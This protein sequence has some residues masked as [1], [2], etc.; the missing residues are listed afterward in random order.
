VHESIEV[1]AQSQKTN[2]VEYSEGILRPVERNILAP[3]PTK[4][5]EF[6]VKNR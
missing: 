1:R 4:V 3:P 5:T 6:E 2:A